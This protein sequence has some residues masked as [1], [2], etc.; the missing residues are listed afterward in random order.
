MET[1][2]INN[3]EFNNFGSNNYSCGMELVSLYPA[4]ANI[5]KDVL[6]GKYPGLYLNPSAPCGSEFFG[7]YGTPEQYEEF[8]KRQRDS[9]ISSQL[10]AKIGFNFDHPNYREIEAEVKA[11]YKDWWL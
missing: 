3:T 5:V 2:T 11:N 6:E 9:Q 10:L 7:V 8:Y 4:P 1:I